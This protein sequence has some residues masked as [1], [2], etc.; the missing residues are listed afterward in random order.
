M[1]QLEVDLR[2]RNV[3]GWITDE[4]RKNDLDFKSAASKV[5]DEH[6]LEFIEYVDGL[7]GLTL[8]EKRRVLDYSVD[9]VYLFA[10]F[11]M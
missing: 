5:Y 8:E 2:F 7:N 9:Q 4:Q 11:S 3:V 6:A 10:A 1:G